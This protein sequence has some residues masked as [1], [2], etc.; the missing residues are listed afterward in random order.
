MPGHVSCVY[1]CTTKKRGAVRVWVGCNVRM[2]IISGLY[3]IA[4]V[5]PG[6]LGFPENL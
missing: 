5:L 4:N 2:Q 1:N 3:T 6:K